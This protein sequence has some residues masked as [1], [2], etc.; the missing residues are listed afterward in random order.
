MSAPGNPRDRFASVVRADEVDLAEAALLMGVEVD[1]TFDPAAGIA[2]LDRLAAAVRAEAGAGYD[3]ARAAAALALVLGGRARFFGQQSDY[4][5][6]R[7][8]LLH[9]VLRR[10]RGLPILLSVVWIEVGRR[11]GLPVYGVALPGHFVVGIGDPDGA[12]ELADP[13]HG[14]VP[15]SVSRARRLA[16]EAGG[17]AG[18]P[19]LLQPARPTAI[20][21][22]VL[23]NIRAWA[24]QPE[25][26]IEGAWTR[27]WAVELSLL[28]PR[29]PAALR[30]ERGS[31][32]AKTGQFAAGARQLQEYAELVERIDP[33]VA[34]GV[35][36]EA[37]AARARLN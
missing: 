5:D 22:R 13:F 20:L 31:L 18:D 36:A 9:E 32:L 8:S 15:L 14:G 27:L 35:L 25:R 28:L 34:E 26:G 6:L 30:H 1:P 17:Q 19:A 7:S 3:P 37:K 23:N 4:A 12:F 24:A 16:A 10:R 33:K 29:H 11:A 2:E 21:L